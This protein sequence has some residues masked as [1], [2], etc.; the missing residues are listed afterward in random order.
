M[1][2]KIKKKLPIGIE[3]FEK[4]RIE[5]FYYIDK[6]GLIKALLYN[7]GEVNLFTRP[8]RFGKSLNMSM[9]K[10]FFEI[11]TD[12]EYKKNLFE[13]LDIAN[14]T[15]LCKT[16]MGKFPVISISL[17]GVNGTDFSAA[18][19]MMSS[20]IGNE[21]LRFYFLSES[22][23]LNEKEIKLF[24]QLTEVDESNR[25]GFI[26]SDTVLT[27]SLKILSMLLQKHY[28]KKVII[29]I[30]EYDVPLAKAFDN[31]Y[32]DEMVMLI[33]NLFEQV[34]KTNDSLQF[35]VLTGCLR[36]S[37]ES[38][39]TGLNNL[40]VLSITDVR[41]DEY[42][43][44]TDK[45]VQDLLKYY[46]LTEFYGIV[47]DWY[48]G[49]RFG[50]VHIYCPWD[51]ICYCD[52]LRF[53][54]KALP[55]DYW[56]NTSSN[57]AVRHFIENAETN[58]TKRE[59]ERLVE[60]DIIK[61]EIRRELTYRELYNNAENIWSVLYTTGYLT[62][63][64]EPDGDIFPLVIPNQEVRKIFTKQITDWFQDTV[65]K[66]GA[67]LNAFCEAFEKGDAAEVEKQF[68]SYLRKTISIRDTFVKKDRKE[69]FYHGILLGLLSFKGN[70]NVWSN[71][72][73][74][75]GYSDILVE[76]EDKDMGIVVEVKYSDDENLEAVCRQALKQI[77]DKNY[78]EELQQLGLNHILK[79]GIACYKKRCKV[80]S[81]R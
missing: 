43:G 20:I 68:N 44:F 78:P 64:G 28:E 24:N 38:I 39:F 76:I 8:R 27:S 9:L 5:D 79:F 60:G 12:K 33:R 54:P 74:G 52:E 47:K 23:K 11:N 57:E 37:K 31:G 17:K 14:D 71:R 66:D 50:N 22:P 35:A 3:S 19:S 56:S 30:D 6:T 41:F 42:F 63:Q 18:R 45:E 46:E 10:S 80:I 21:A 67:A 25:E 77:N 32:Y 29:L 59:I 49:Y 51:V 15:D 1:N 48:D 73:S 7:W 69:N 72:E 40:K 2:T 16:Y 13:G 4:I 53:D 36:V 81:L 26:M 70:W 61:K 62:Q 58:T 75:E 34:L 65:R 55:K